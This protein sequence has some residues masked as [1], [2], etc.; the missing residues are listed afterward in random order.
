M[1]TFMKKVK[2]G[3]RALRN[4]GK[5]VSNFPDYK[6]YVQ[7]LQESDPSII[8]PTEAEFFKDFL[9]QRYGASAKRCC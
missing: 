2:Q 3:C 6:A 9:D 4:I 5:G 8:P 1:P 7:H